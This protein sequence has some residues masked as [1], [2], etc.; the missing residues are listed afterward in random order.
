MTID[1]RHGN[2]RPAAEGGRAA[3]RRARLQEGDRPRH[4][5]RRA[6]QRRRGQLSLRRQARALPRGA[7]VGDRRDAR[8]QRRRARGRRGAAAGGAAAPLHRASSCT[9]CSTPGNDTVH[10]LINREM[11]DPTPA[12]DALVEQGVRPRVEYL[13]G[14]IARDHRLRRRRTSACCAASPASR[15]RSLAYLPNP[16]AARLG[17]ANK[18]T[19]GATSTRSP[20][21]SRSSRSPACTPSAAP[22]MPADPAD[23]RLRAGGASRRLD[24][25][26]AARPLRSRRHRRRHRGSG[27][28][29]GRGR[30]RRARRA[31]RA[32][33]AR[34]RLPEHRLRAV[35][36]APALGPRGRGGAAR[37][38]ARRPRRP[39]SRPTSPSVMRRMRERRADISPHDSAARL[40]AAGVDVYFG[41]ARFTGAVDDCRRRPHADVPPR[42]D[43][44]RRPAGG[45]ADSRP[46]RP[47]RT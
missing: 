29:D 9:A 47:C 31:G 34:R 15:R 38:G 18:P 7:A 17:F 40:R 6:R 41:D 39:A 8:H 36:G 20:S 30:T 45:A 35:E 24:Q 16:I 11:N 27:E 44:H 26:R 33:A 3:V 43:R 19:A 28:R 25:S 23:A 32:R 1:A 21:T 37:A 12:L 5:P 46:R 2:A 42:G 13:S 14:L 22:C 4:L 10:K